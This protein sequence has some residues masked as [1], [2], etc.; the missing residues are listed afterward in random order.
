MFTKRRLLSCPFCGGE[1]EVDFD[2]M[3]IENPL[4]PYSV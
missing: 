3:P 2:P 4:Y 1:A